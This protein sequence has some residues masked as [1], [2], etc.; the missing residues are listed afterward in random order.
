MA[1]ITELHKFLSNKSSVTDLTS[2]R[3]YQTHLPQSFDWSGPAVSMT[4]ISEE[5]PH[6]LTNSAGVATARVQID[7]WGTNEDQVENVAEAIRL[8][9]DSYSGPVGS[10]TVLAALLDNVV[11][12]PERP[13]DGSNQWRQHIACDYLITYR[14]IVAPA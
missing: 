9:L 2:T 5:H 7:S 6:T 1:L 4:K 11:S 3:M 14:N 13:T 10:V 12:L 8:V